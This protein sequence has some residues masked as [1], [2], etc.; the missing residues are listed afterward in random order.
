M[1]AQLS[2]ALIALLAA[3]GGASGTPVP[4]TP[5]A[6]CDS[7]DTLRLPVSWSVREVR[8]LRRL[9]AIDSHLVGTWSP[10]PFETRTALRTAR[11]VAREVEEAVRRWVPSDTGLPVRIDLLAFETWS[12]PV[13]GPDPVR[14]AVRLRVVSLDSSR[15][16][17]LLEPRAQ[18]ERKAAARAVD[19]TRLLM[20]LLR[21]ALATIQPP[22]RPSPDTGGAAPEFVRWADPAASPAPADTVGRRQLRQIVSAN[23]VLAWRGVG[24]GLRYVQYLEPSGAAWTPEYWGGLQLRGPWNNDEWSHVWAGELQGGMAWHRRL[25]AGASPW[26][27]VASMGGM[28]GIE[29]SRPSHDDGSVGERKTFLTLGAEGR[30]G[31]RREPT[32]HLGLVWSAGPQLDLRLPSRLGWFDPGAYLEVGWKF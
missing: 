32:N 7:A 12:D 25:D 2:F 14:A 4:S 11:P 15:P 18:G 22:F 8:D 3:C 29:G 27:V 13:P 21:D 6:L 10:L 26:L 19:Q 16:G 23:A 30:F 9:A 17:L 5:V 20:S 24:A 28:L 1:N 31:I